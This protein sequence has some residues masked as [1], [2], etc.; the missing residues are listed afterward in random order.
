MSDEPKKGIH[1]YGHD[2]TEHAAL[3]LG[4]C[5]GV[6]CR[7]TEEDI[8]MLASTG[9]A[10]ELMQTIWRIGKDLH[11]ILHPHKAAE[12]RADEL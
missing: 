12:A 1:I 4:I 2:V 6:F 7:Y 11:P 8:N 5:S 10:G 9:Y 3:A